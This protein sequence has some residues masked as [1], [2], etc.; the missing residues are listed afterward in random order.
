MN[1][2]KFFGII[3]RSKDT[4]SLL[5]ARRMLKQTERFYLRETA[6]DLSGQDWEEKINWNHF[7]QMK[8]SLNREISLN[9]ND[10]VTWHWR[11]CSSLQMINVESQEKKRFWWIDGFIFSL[12]AILLRKIFRGKERRCICIDPRISSFV[13][14]CSNEMSLVA[15]IDQ[16]TEKDVESSEDR[17]DQRWSTSKI[18]ISTMNMAEVP[19][20][21]IVRWDESM[22]KNEDGEI[23]PFKIEKRDLWFRLLLRHCNGMEWTT[24]FHSDWWTKIIEWSRRETIENKTQLCNEIFNE[25]LPRRNTIFQHPNDRKFNRKF[26]RNNLRMNVFV[27]VWSCQRHFSFLNTTFLSSQRFWTNSGRTTEFFRLNSFA[28][29]ERW[30]SSHVIN[31]LARSERRK[32]CWTRSVREKH[33]LRWWRTTWSSSWLSSSS[34]T[35]LANR[36]AELLHWFLSLSQFVKRFAK[37]TTVASA[38]W[39]FLQ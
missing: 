21:N 35:W 12:S 19:W 14:H 33:Y 31:T 16:W 27:F 15:Y 22:L 26:P 20:S 38:W 32:R 9:F 37:K 28:D 7:Q 8:R 18:V 17:F 25:H 30:C 4:L 24:L 1:S 11:M 36:N 39:T 13:Q 5:G 29:V 23:L 2:S 34:F 3:I 10:Q 6:L